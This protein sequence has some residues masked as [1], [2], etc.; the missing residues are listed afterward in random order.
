MADLVAPL[1]AQRAIV[2]F[3]LWLTAAAAIMWVPSFKADAANTMSSA[4]QPLQCAS[5]STTGQG[6]RETM[7]LAN[8]AVDGEIAD[9]YAFP[10]ISGVPWKFEV[11]LAN[12]GGD[13]TTVPT[14]NPWVLGVVEGMYAKNPSNNFFY[15]A[16]S[17]VGLYQIAFKALRLCTTADLPV[18]QCG[19]GVNNLDSGTNLTRN[20][21]GMYAR[22]AGTASNAP[23][24]PYVLRMAPDGP[25]T[26]G[27]G[28][29]LTDILAEGTSTFTVGP[30]NI[31]LGGTGCGIAGGQ[32]WPSGTFDTMHTCQG[33]TLADMAGLAWILGVN[34]FYLKQINLD[35]KYLLTHGGTTTNPYTDPPGGAANPSV[36][37]ALPN[38]RISVCAT[39]TPC[40]PSLDYPTDD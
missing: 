29:V 34:T 16:A 33:I 38:T 11:G 40:N 5:N 35:F 7:E 10:C 14:C 1:R 6:R 30:E 26:L 32:K 36:T 8:D 27:G 17:D 23:T 2:L 37:V 22:S 39:T 9:T 12:T 21:S 25:V 15:A 20:D 28:G 4:Y 19:I 24:K 3:S 13:C 31:T 18:T